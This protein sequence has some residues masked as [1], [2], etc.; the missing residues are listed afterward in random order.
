[1]E[2][3]DEAQQLGDT[4]D[5]TNDSALILSIVSY[6]M[7]DAIATAVVLAGR[8][9]PAVMTALHFRRGLRIAFME[10]KDTFN[11]VMRVRAARGNA[12]NA[13]DG[14]DSGDAAEGVDPEARDAILDSVASYTQVLTTAPDTT[15]DSV[16]RSVIDQGITAL[17]TGND[18]NDD[19]DD[20]GTGGVVVDVTVQTS[21]TSPDDEGL[22]S[23][24]HDEDG[25]GGTDSDSA[26][27]SG[28]GSGDDGSV[29]LE[30]VYAYM[31]QIEQAFEA[32]V[33]VSDLERC[34][35]GALGG[36]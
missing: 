17:T 25:D 31:E 4:A 30:D 7:R 8:E 26:S 27:G 19:N 1:M 29:S 5:S 23:G 15:L 16:M 21:T 28:S 33:P 2:P 12:E 32:Y 13:S 11:A 6:L 3:V 34:L 20:D 10:N 36:Q 24:G 14:G 35:V 18:D 9:S 22:L